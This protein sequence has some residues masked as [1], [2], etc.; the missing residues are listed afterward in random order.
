MGAPGE[1]RLF[2]GSGRPS[3]R[4]QP[5]FIE[6]QRS[7]IRM[8][9]HIRG[10]GSGPI[11]P[12]AIVSEYQALVAVDTHASSLARCTRQCLPQ[13]HHVNGKEAKRISWAAQNAKRRYRRSGTAFSVGRSRQGTT[14]S[15]VRACQRSHGSQPRDSIGG[16][17]PD[18]SI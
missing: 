5:R 9:S 12:T 6:A 8:A 4:K 1:Q 14:S 7:R 18:P 2:T 10:L 17:E 13:P 3:R 11:R 15:V 16:A